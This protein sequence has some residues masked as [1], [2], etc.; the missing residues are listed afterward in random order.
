MKGAPR[1]PAAAAQSV[2]GMLPFH[3]GRHCP[4][5]TTMSSMCV[6]LA[7]A[8]QD[9]PTRR[10]RAMDSGP[11]LPRGC[12]LWIPGAVGATALGIDPVIDLGVDLG[13]RRFAS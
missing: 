13:E 1:A 7:F 8:T 10:P 11:S 2:V 5:E 12:C 3:V 9:H 4:A 6:A